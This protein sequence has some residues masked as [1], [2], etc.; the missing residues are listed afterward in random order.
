MQ[1]PP[2]MFRLHETYF[3]NVH[4]GNIFDWFARLQDDFHFI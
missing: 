1:N 2:Q 4:F 3:W